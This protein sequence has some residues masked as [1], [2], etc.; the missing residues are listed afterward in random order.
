MKNFV[1]L[2]FSV[3]NWPMKRNFQPQKLTHKIKFQKFSPDATFEQSQKKFQGIWKIENSKIAWADVGGQRCPCPFRVSF[4]PGFSVKSCPMSVCCPDSVRILD[5]KAVR[6]LSA[7]PNKDETELS[8][9]SL[10][11]STDVY[12]GG[13]KLWLQNSF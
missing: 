9:P 4:Y 12:F 8:G 10:S 1:S 7:R 5:K 3:N 2:I 6:C 11:L 13:W